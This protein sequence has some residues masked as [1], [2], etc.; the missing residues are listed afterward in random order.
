MVRGRARV[1]HQHRLD[2][3]E[4]LDL[5]STALTSSQLSSLALLPSL[6]RFAPAPFTLD[7]GRAFSI[8]EVFDLREL[9]LSFDDNRLAVTGAHIMLVSRAI[10]GRG[11]VLARVSSFTLRGLELAS[12][13]MAQILAYAPAL[14]KLALSGMSA[15]GLVYAL[16]SVS[17]VH[18]SLL[19]SR[20]EFPH[21]TSLATTSIKLRSC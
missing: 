7:P 15:A 2:R 13:E 16:Q 5:H 3:L 21:L 14:T 10:Q 19:S 6:T 4:H 8:F 9:Q 17:S 11:C 20:V 18:A 1:V 12:F